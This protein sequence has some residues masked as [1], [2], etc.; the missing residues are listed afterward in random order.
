M[1]TWNEVTNFLQGLGMAEKDGYWSGFYKWDDGRL[2]TIV[3]QKIDLEGDA[4]DGLMVA[5][6][7][8]LVGDITAD[9]ALDLATIYGVRRFGG[10]YCLTD[11]VPIA[12]LD[13]N[14][15]LVTLQLLARLADSAEQKHSTG[16]SH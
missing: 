14:E 12:D 7:F 5:S 6:P 11:F 1:A 3:A 2:Q 9:Q 13:D 8:A 10:R 16:D 4:V 15:V